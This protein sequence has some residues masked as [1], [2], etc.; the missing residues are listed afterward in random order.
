MIN[1]S[2]EIFMDDFTPYGTTFEDALQNLEKVLKRCIEAHLALSTEK[3]HMMMNEVIVL[4]HFVSF[5]GIQVDPAKIQ[6]K[7]QLST[8]PI[9]RGP[10]WALP[11]HIS[12]DASDTAIGVV[13]GHEEN[14]LP[15]AIYFI[16]KNMTP[17]ELNYTVTQKEFLAVI[18]AINKFQHYITGYTTFVHTNHSAIKYLMNKSVTNA[19]VTRWLLLLQEFDIT[20]VD[21]PRKEN[22][23]ADFLSRLKT[24]ENIPVDDSFPDE[25][26]FAISAHSPWYADIANYLVVGKLPSHLPHREKRKI[27]QQSARYSWISGCLFHTGLNQ[28][29][30]RCIGEDQ[31]YDVLKACHDGPCGGHFAD[32]RTAHK[33][34]R[35]GYYWPSI[36]KDAK[37]YVRACDS[38][39]R[40]GQPNHRDEMPF[41]PQV[42]LEPFE[43]W[44]LEFIGPIN[45]PSN[46][47]VYILVC[48]D[49]M[50]KWVEAKA[51]IKAN[52]ESVLTFLFE[53]IFVRFGLPRELVTDG[54]P[55]FNSHGF[56]DTL[57]KYHI[58]H[59]MTTPYHPQSNGQVESTNKVIETILTKTIK[60]NR[61]DWFQ[62]LPEALWAYRT[63]WRNTTGFSPYELVFGKNVVFPLEFEIKTLRTALAVNLDL[64]DAQTARL[65]QLQ[66]AR[67]EK[68]WMPSP[69]KKP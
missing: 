11:F 44:A 18:Y 63:T 13:L 69:K 32:K 67:R 27:I 28:E 34:L 41:N 4:G 45:P 38:C 20:I 43:R 21:R 46:Q 9:L 12:S 1:D 51:L 42:I 64:T 23:V 5:L 6:L 52:E 40:M 49:Y 61:R 56:K 58:K 31:I 19:R 15:Y 7:H 55:P 53:E 8:A 25:Y 57:Q 39:Q 10:D 48:T 3:C 30:R 50:T 29:I 35:M 24:N 66:G 37:K 17:A 62:K 16:S 26:L 47:R 59:R 68:N 60:E 65:Q 14:S 22:V 36:F 2:L 33:V 54:G